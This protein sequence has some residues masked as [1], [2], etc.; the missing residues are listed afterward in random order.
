MKDKLLQIIEDIK[1]RMQADPMTKRVGLA[2]AFFTMTA[3]LAAVGGLY[4]KYSAAPSTAGATVAVAPAATTQAAPVQ[5]LPASAPAQ[6]TTPAA[7]AGPTLSLTSAMMSPA[8]LAKYTLKPGLEQSWSYSVNDDALPSLVGSVKHEK[9]TCDFLVK[10]DVSMASQ[11]V[12]GRNVSLTTDTSCQFVV[13]VQSE[14]LL[15]TVANGKNKYVLKLYIDDQVV[16]TA[17]YENHLIGGKAVV[18]IPASQL[19]AAGLHR[20]RV[21]VVTQY[22]NADLPLTVRVSIKTPAD[23]TLVD[24]QP[25]FVTENPVPTAPAAVPVQPASTPA[26]ETK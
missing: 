23:Q 1:C 10:P 2:I 6:T 15:N 26:G 20:L 7:V 19:L 8:E 16:P 24:L 11:I 18:S 25:V 5:I 17:E 22:K 4:Q 13:P 12:P 3:A 14:V 9:K 21:V